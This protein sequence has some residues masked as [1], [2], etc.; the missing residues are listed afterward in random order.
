MSIEVRNIGKNFGKFVALD[1]VTLNIPT[2]E[3]VALLG[4]SGSGKTTLL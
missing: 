2:G 3:L 1:D 4:P